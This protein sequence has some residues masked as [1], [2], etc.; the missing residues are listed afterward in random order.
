MRFMVVSS[1]A[2]RFFDR[3]APLFGRMPH[4]ASATERPEARD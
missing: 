2:P 1:G 4:A 3:S